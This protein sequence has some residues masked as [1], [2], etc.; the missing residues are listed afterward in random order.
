MTFF[1]DRPSIAAGNERLAVSTG[2]RFAQSIRGDRTLSSDAPVCTPGA[3]RIHPLAV[4]V[5]IASG[6]LALIPATALGDSNG[7]FENITVSAT[8][9]SADVQDVPYNISA[10]S[11]EALEELRIE[12]LAQFARWVPG[13][14]L[15]D[16]GQRAA[17]LLTVRGLNAS[18]IVASEALGNNGGGTVATYVGDIPVYV[19]LRPLDIERVEVLMGPQG[20]L[21]GSGTL[22]GAVRYIPKRP[23]TDAASLDLHARGYTLAE[24]DS[25]GYGADAAF[26]IPINDRL[27]FRGVVGYMKE[28]GFVD[29]NFIVGRDRAGKISPEDFAQLRRKKDAD[30][31]EIMSARASLLWHVTDD[32]DAVFT[33]HYQDK[34]SGG[35]TINHVESFG[36]GKYEA[37]H[38]FLEPNER[39]NQIFSLEVSA[40][41]ELGPL[42][43]VEL[44]SATGY[45]MYRDDGQRDQTDLLLNFG[46]G[47]EDFPEFSAF[48]HDFS[49]E[50]TFTQELRVV[51]AGDSRWNWIAGAFYS[52]FNID[53]TS[54][55]FTPGIPEFFGIAPPPLPTGDLEYQSVQKSSEEQ[56][57]VFGELGYRLTDNWQI[58]GGMR[59]FD[60][61]IKDRIQ[62]KIPLVALTNTTNPEPI[63]ENNVIFKFNTSYQLDDAIPGM[64]SGNL[65]FTFSQ[66]YRTGGFN[67][68]GECPDPLP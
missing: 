43:P 57:A 41:F 13:L 60:Y 36:T 35:R 27:A 5:A 44:V 56:V 33:Y 59:W 8:R 62:V 39:Q 32:V 40:D 24:S 11:G 26:N 38:R 29:Y 21:Y 10:Y 66:G 25:P 64:D 52:K 55:E 68:V 51:S 23:S 45:S 14:T 1:C 18:S 2:G 4:A 15:V 63:S 31:L 46:Y 22:A 30:D 34:K 53:G 28:A 47:Y 50:D 6:S 54:R 16:Q 65:Y 20:T 58:T 17:N 19:D 67:G 61:R 9:R 7:L 37:A 12:D 49:D 42:G 48:T 3:V